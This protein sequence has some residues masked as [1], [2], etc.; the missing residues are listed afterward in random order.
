MKLGLPWLTQIQGNVDPNQ[1]TPT[2]M[3][4]WIGQ[5]LKVLVAGISTGYHTEHNDNDTHK[6]IHATG[7]IYEQGR[8]TAAGHWIAAVPAASDFS[9]T[10]PL[11]WTV[12]PTQVTTWEYTLI[13]KTLFLNFAVTGSTEGGAA[14]QPLTLKIPGHFATTEAAHQCFGLFEYQEGSTYGIG[15]IIVQ[16]NLIRLY[17]AA[18]ANWLGS[19]SLDVHGQVAFEIA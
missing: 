5:T 17:K 9:A 7:P 12:S 18:R 10:L 3:G 19:G 11:T 16:A 1:I 8:T 15:A 4:G 6:T 2:T 13:G 14:G